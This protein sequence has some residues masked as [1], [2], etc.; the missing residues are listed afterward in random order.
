LSAHRPGWHAD[1]PDACP[2]PESPRSI[3]TLL[4]G[5]GST[6]TSTPDKSPPW[7]TDSKS[8]PPSAPK[9]EGSAGDARAVAMGGSSG[10]LGGVGGR[11]GA[12]V[13]RAS[14]ERARVAGDPYSSGVVEVDNEAEAWSL[15][16]AELIALAG[17]ETEGV[18]G[19]GGA[20]FR[21]RLELELQSAG[22]K[23]YEGSPPHEEHADDQVCVAMRA[24]QRELQRVCAANDQ[25]REVIRQRVQGKLP[26]LQ[27]ELELWR[28]R[29]HVQ[30][31]HARTFGARGGRLPMPLSEGVPPVEPGAIQQALLAHDAALATTRLHGDTV[32]SFD[33]WDV[34]GFD[35]QAA[36]A[37]AVEERDD[38]E[39]GALSPSAKDAG[40]SAGVGSASSP[41]VRRAFDTTA[42]SSSGAD[43]C[44]LP[45]PREKR[46]VKAI[47]NSD[48]SVEAGAPLPMPIAPAV[49]SAGHN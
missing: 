41:P 16:E 17:S 43:S 25:K 19:A 42:G 48:E 33:W 6:K 37:A 14:A 12:I 31:L 13:E 36:A 2:G 1:K 22:L 30:A 34:F 46:L 29:Y 28:T 21:R 5:H 49:G 18:G 27:R 26:E 45:D 47:T 10:M 32:T 23:E 40:H 44:L 15:L 38:D 3:Q 24:A 39:C 7:V 9:V 20:E 11:G 8:S 35:K 4:S